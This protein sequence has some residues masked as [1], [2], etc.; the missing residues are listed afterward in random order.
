MSRRKSATILEGHIIYCSKECQSEDNNNNNKIKQEKEEFEKLLNMLNE[1]DNEFEEKLKKLK[2]EKELRKF[3]DEE[4]N[5][6]G[7]ENA[8]N[9]TFIKELKEQLCEF[10][11]LK[12][13]MLE[14]IKILTLDNE[15]Y[16]QEIIKLKSELTKHSSNFNVIEHS[17]QNTDSKN[18]QEDK[19]ENTEKI[20]TKNKK[21]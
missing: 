21:S 18:G 20:E 11:E 9:E 16:A 3:N 14:S 7:K 1:K 19:K 8:E 2:K 10:N 12:N 6:L 4:I 15:V 13:S 17:L 5:R